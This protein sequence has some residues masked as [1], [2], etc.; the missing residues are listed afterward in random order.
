M[1][2]GHGLKY[3]TDDR[4]CGQSIWTGVPGC[5][6]NGVPLTGHLVGTRTQTVATAV[7]PPAA[8]PLPG[9]QVALVRRSPASRSAPPLTSAI[10]RPLPSRPSRRA[11]PARAAPRPPRLGDR[12][13]HVPAVRGAPRPCAG[14]V[15]GSPRLPVAAPVLAPLVRPRVAPASPGE[16]PP[17]PLAPPRPA[18][19]LRA[20]PG[21]CGRRS[22]AKAE[23]SYC[24]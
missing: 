2:K 5:K 4:S 10:L 9:E 17:T 8:R 6:R 20:A 22:R 24:S 15:G 16:P 23:L 21:G 14:E 7:R 19:L 3:Q 11:S 1:P 12:R 13:I 18:P